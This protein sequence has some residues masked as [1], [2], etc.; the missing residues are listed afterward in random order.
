MT[1]IAAGPAP[2]YR[3]LNRTQ[4]RTLAATNL[5][6]LFDG[7][8]TYALFLTVGPAMRSL[9]EPAQHPHIPHYIGIVVA[10]T[11]L[12]W[13]TGGLIG[14]VLADYIGR[15]RTMIYAM[16]AYSIMTGLTALSFSW[17]SFALLR[18]LVGIAIGSE[19]ATGSSMIAELWPANARGRGAGLM[20]CGLA[21][22][23]FVASLVWLVIG[24]LGPS[25]WRVMFLLGVLPALLTMWIRTSIDESKLWSETNARRCA[26]QAR[27]DG[28]AALA[29][30][31]RALTRFTLLDLFGSHELRRR[32]V[33]LF[34]MSLATTLAWWGIATWVPPFVASV[35]A[36]A[37]KPAH[38][39]ASYAGM[40]YNFG[41]LLGYVCLGFAADRLGRRPVT[42]CYFALALLMTPVLFLWTRNLDLLLIAAALN[43]FFT[44][45]L[46]SW[47]P[48]W[49]PE[50]FPTRSRATGVAF[51]FN[52]P[53]FIAFLGPIFAG[54]L[55]DRLGGYSQAATI[56]SAIYVLGLVVTPF[57]PE[58]RGR[59][60]MRCKRAG[61]PNPKFASS[62]LQCMANFGFGTL[63]G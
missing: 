21:I 28:G 35:A 63:V 27:R 3:A 30:D 48:V 36:A 12:G 54:N 33:L 9:L 50:L 20:Q 32:V 23:F 47:M 26:A 25:S 53:R 59:F 18:F 15:K 7:F 49:L 19:W 34:A 62:V 39:W 57:L 58:T 14:G 8:E 10:I 17:E 40:T 38:E 61:A 44:L 31:E 37:G 60:R 13:G 51:V 41:A 29:A 2:W 45:G 24:E 16:L 52:A 55:I 1:D 4:W 42:F 5:G 46:F 43:G 11:L 22:G 56:I 6:W